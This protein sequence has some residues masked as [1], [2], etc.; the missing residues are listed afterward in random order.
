MRSSHV[1]LAMFWLFLYCDLPHFSRFCIVVCYVLSTSTKWCEGFVLSLSFRWTWEYND[2]IWP[3]LCPGSVVFVGRGDAAAGN[4]I[5]RPQLSPGSFS[6][7][8]W[9][10]CFFFWLIVS[11]MGALHF[12]FIILWVVAHYTIYFFIFFIFPCIWTIGLLVKGYLWRPS[13]LRA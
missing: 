3:H 5:C 8:Q 6:F 2:V 10:R 4:R 13:V 7:G 11:F 9:R 12:Q 1:L